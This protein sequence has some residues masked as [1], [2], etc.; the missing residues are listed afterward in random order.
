M[1]WGNGREPTG[2]QSDVGFR[3][4]RVGGTNNTKN[5]EYGMRRI[6]VKRILGLMAL[7]FLTIAVTSPENA[8]ARRF[9]SSSR[10]SNL[11]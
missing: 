4:Q 10:G 6:S 5:E 11:K 7:S 3:R 2:V 9:G 1:S 8:E